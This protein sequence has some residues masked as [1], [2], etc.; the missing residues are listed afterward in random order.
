MTRLMFVATYS[1][2]P[3]SANPTRAQ[4]S[5]LTLMFDDFLYP[6][7]DQTII[8]YGP[9]EF[10]F[11]LLKFYQQFGINAQHIELVPDH[12]LIAGIDQHLLD[13]RP[14]IR[15]QLLKLVALDRCTDTNILIQ[16]CDIFACRPY[17]WIRDQQVNLFAI[18]NTQAP[19]DEWYSYVNKFTGYSRFDSHCYMN[20]FL[21]IT[22]Y[23]WLALREHI[24]TKY[25]REWLEAMTWQ[26]RQD[27]NQGQP[28]EFSEFELLSA[29]LLHQGRA[30]VTAQRRISVP[31][32]LYTA[33]NLS[34][35]SWFVTQAQ[36]INPN[37]VTM[38]N[39]VRG[40]EIQAVANIVRRWIESCHE[41]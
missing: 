3:R 10:D 25:Q 6:R 8:Y 39:N 24:E 18:E 12:E 15:Q 23:D 13:F 4:D 9:S 40:T 31:A 21:P 2:H 41:S 7:I 30:M 33:A 20:E 36:K 38:A 22:R 28:L 37:C 5:A 32:P 35:E 29:W 1:P 19:H 34:S 27:M 14:A 16:D 11:D 26:F 17:R